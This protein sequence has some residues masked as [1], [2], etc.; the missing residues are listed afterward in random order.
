MGIGTRKTSCL[1]MAI[2]THRRY[3]H[4]DYIVQTYLDWR[5][6]RGLRRWRPGI[7]YWVVDLRGGAGERL[8]TFGARPTRDQDPA[9]LNPNPPKDGLGDS[10]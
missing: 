5:L 8:A 9:V 2:T 10:P 4:S 6:S 7:G 1:L 3:F